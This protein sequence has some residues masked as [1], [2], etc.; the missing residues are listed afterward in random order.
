MATGF[1]IVGTGMIAQFHAHAIEAIAD[2]KLVGCFDMAAERADAFAEKNGCLAYSQLEE[3][4]ANPEI[5]V[6][7]ICTPSGSHRDPA[8]AAAQ[9]GKH[10]LVEKPLEITLERCDA[11]IN[12]CESNNVRLGTILPSRFSPANMASSRPLMPDDSAG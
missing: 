12:A 4:L 5:A 11:I 8:V 1:G 7:T 3:M 2:A 9:A 6:I 10:V